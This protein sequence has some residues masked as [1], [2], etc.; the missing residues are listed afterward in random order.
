MSSRL[1]YTRE[2]LKEYLKTRPPGTDQIIKRPAQK[3]VLKR[4]NIGGYEYLANASRGVFPVFSYILRTRV[5]RQK[6]SN[7][8]VVGE[9]GDG[10]SYISFDIARVL[11]R[12]G[13]HPRNFTVDQ[14]VLSYGEFL[15]QIVKLRL[16]RPLAFDEPSYAMS[17]RDWYKEINKAL[18]LTIESFRFKV[19]PLFIPII[20]MNLLDKTIRQH[21]IQFCVEMKDRGRARVYRMRSKQHEDGYY[22]HFLC[23][24]RYRMFDNELCSR[25]SCLDCSKVDTCTIFRA[26]YERKKRDVQDERYKTSL[27]KFTEREA[28]DL[29]DSQIEEL[30]LTCVLEFRKDD[31]DPDPTAMRII[32]EDRWNIKIGRNRSYKIAKGLK[33]RYPAKFSKTEAE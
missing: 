19:H 1:I 18:V 13:I 31:G 20:N 27:E 26:Q 17:K 11:A 8:A 32:L 6:A 16:G 4:I 10:K 7:I 29:S 3:P 2:D 22:R 25:A 28:R 33:I 5:K 9:P 24:L 15:K 21:L 30:L 23:D 12:A 14:V